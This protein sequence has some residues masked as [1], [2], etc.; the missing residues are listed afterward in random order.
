MTTSRSF[1]VIRMDRPPLERR[2]RMFHKSGLV[3]R[4]RV[5][6]DL[7]VILIRNLQTGIDRSGCRPPVFVEL[8][9]ASA[10]L[11]LFDQPDRG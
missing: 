7:N 1:G 11:N 2:L 6:A 4:I 10:P 9:P 3:Q 5:D 8:Q